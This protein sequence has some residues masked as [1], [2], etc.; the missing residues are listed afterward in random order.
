MISVHTPEEFGETLHF[1]GCRA[2]TKKRAKAREQEHFRKSHPGN[3]SAVAEK[4]EQKPKTTTKTPSGLVA[5]A[6]TTDSTS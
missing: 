2:A 1:Q 6:F 5:F 3:D 4:P